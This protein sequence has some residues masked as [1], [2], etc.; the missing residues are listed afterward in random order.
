[1]PGPLVFFQVEQGLY[2]FKVRQDGLLRGL[3]GFAA[4][5]THQELCEPFQQVV[6][7]LSFG[8]FPMN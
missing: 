6:S 2:Q 5:Q 7:A 1:M 8:H 3:R 4:R